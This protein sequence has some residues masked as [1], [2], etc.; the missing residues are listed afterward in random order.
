[1]QNSKTKLKGGWRNWRY[2]PFREIVGELSNK[3][4]AARKKCEEMKITGGQD[5]VILLKDRLNH[6]IHDTNPLGKICLS[7]SDYSH[8]SDK[9]PD[10][11]ITA[12]QICDYYSNQHNFYIF[13]WTEMRRKLY[14][15]HTHID[16]LTRYY[17]H[18]L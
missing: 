6:I 5:A 18:F 7:K 12:K 17:F 1:L 4:E 15:Y 9:Y 10:V 16:W 11:W 13:K 2:G 8:I 14:L 3:S